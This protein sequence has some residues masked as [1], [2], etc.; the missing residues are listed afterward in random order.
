MAQA[1]LTVSEAAALLH[2]HADTIKRSLRAGR[3]K[4]YKAA[5][6]KL[7]RI[8]RES[9]RSQLSPVETDDILNASAAQDPN[10]WRKHDPQAAVSLLRSL[11]T[12]D[13][14]QQRAALGELARAVDEDRAGQR[15]AFGEGLSS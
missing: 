12:G 1:D 2:V 14:Q 4:G 10:A 6:G 8:P 7:W 11:R 13:V 15:L 5:G 9:L 3:L